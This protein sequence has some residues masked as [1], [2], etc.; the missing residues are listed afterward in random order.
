MN[1]KNDLFLLT[2]L[3][4]HDIGDQNIDFLNIVSIAN[5]QYLTAA[6]FWSLYKHGFFSKSRD[7][8]LHA[9]LYEIFQINA[10]R[11]RL[12]I[13]QIKEIVSLLNHEGIEPLLLKGSA[14]LVENDFEHI[15]IRFLSDIDLMVNKE[16]IDR[17]YR[18]LQDAGYSEAKIA[19]IRA[20]YH[21]MPPVQKSDRPVIVELHKRVSGGHSKIEYIPFNSETSMR[22]THSDFSGAWVLKP[23][24]RL[25]HAFLH[26]EIDD[27][28]YM[29]RRLDLRHLHDFCVLANKYA[30][31]I[32][33]DKL[34]ALVRSRKLQKHFNAYLYQA[35]VFFSLDTPLTVETKEVKKHLEGVLKSF[36]MEGSVRGEFYPLMQKLQ[37]WYHP[38]TLKDRYNYQSMWLYPYYLIIQIID[39]LTRY[40]FCKG[41]LKE[42][43][44]KW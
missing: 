32:E 17:A 20:T 25:Y 24:Y 18:L 28:N 13:E 30:D 34:D 35:K 16:D 3:L 19:N 10:Q 33:W 4:T 38:E 11:N 40:V 36:E 22:C 14:A 39:Q 31:K 1:K 23:T 26:T 9:Y 8:E 42:I 43:I 12:I 37:V 7:K 21:H 44:S 41:C 5:R 6:L 2:T 27:K 29:L 15:G